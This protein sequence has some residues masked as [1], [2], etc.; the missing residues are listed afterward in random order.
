MN[1]KSLTPTRVPHMNLWL[2]TFVSGTFKIEGVCTKLFSC[3]CDLL[4]RR[5][6]LLL[7]SS[8][9]DYV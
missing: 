4:E 8:Y 2:H 9:I 7:D 5:A 3:T 1:E 6:Q